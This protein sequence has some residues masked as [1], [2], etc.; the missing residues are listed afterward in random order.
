MS[1][2]INLI[3]P[4]LFGA[5]CIIIALTLKNKS[6]KVIQNGVEVEGIVF[7]FVATYSS[8]Y[9]FIKFPVIR[10]VTTEAVWVT[11]KSDYSYPFLKK[12][13]KVTV[14]YS[15]EDPEEF[16]I[17]TSFDFSK[18]IYLILVIGIFVL[19]FGL[20]SAYFFIIK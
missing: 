3:V 13:K 5:S 9:S 7:D 16:I 15:K 11:K 20:R 1:E 10:F 14:I 2:L 12:G 19:L 17:K 6:N 18:L 4:L 8:D